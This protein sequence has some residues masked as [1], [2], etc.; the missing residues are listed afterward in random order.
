MGT[1]T[2]ERLTVAR[3]RRHLRQQELADLCGVDARSVRAWEKGEWEPDAESVATLSRVLRFPVSFFSAPARPLIEGAS[4]RSQSK[5]TA[6]Q[7]DASLA[8]GV[9]VLDVDGWIRTRFRRPAPDLP[10]LSV[11]A[12][13]EAAAI[14]RE[15]W[16]LG[17][18][19]APNMVHLLEARGVRVYSLPET[20]RAFSAFSFWDED[21]PFVLLNTTSSGERGR[22]D[23]AHELAHLVLHR[24]GDRTTP[25]REREAD[26]FAGAFL[27]PPTPFIGLSRSSLDLEA[28]LTLKRHWRV[29]LVAMVYRLNALNQ[30]SEWRYRELMIEISRRGWRTSEPQS[31]RR[32]TSQVLAKVFGSLRGA[33]DK[34]ATIARAL[35]LLTEELQRLIFGL[36][37]VEAAS[38]RDALAQAL[39]PPRRPARPLLKIVRE[40]QPGAPRRP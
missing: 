16:G 19:P 25:E 30:I 2:P 9:L 39:P 24:S 27:L 40:P 15:R 13:T 8:A 33:N 20:E 17:I 4:F 35:H 26:E 38:S 31:M 29:S 37:V 32:E 21:V 7:R 18:G 28:M 12:P 10:D 23:C 22:F 34:P 36:V 14:L 5:M 11:H 6:S 3:M 1:F